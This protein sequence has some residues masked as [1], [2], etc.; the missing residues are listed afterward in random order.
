MMITFFY[1]GLFGLGLLWLSIRV[2]RVR[3]GDKISMGDGDNK[4]LQ[5]RIRAHGNFAEF[6]PLTLLL[7]YFVE[8]SWKTPWLTHALALCLL[9][10]RASHA[11]AFSA[12]SAKTHFSW[13]KRGMTLTF[14]SLAFASLAL[15]AQTVRGGL[16]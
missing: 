13:R 5:R 3:H 11:Y 9:L 2:V 15:V 4:T 6:V 8:L 12:D 7:I 14:A 10:G 16:F 1:A